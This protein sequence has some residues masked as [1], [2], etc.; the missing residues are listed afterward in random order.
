MEAADAFMHTATSLCPVD[1]GYL[2]SS[3]NA[4]IVGTNAIHVEA[5][6]PYAQYVEYG[7][8]RMSA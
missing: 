7:T 1:T 6:A 3:I 2:L 5:T 4:E 8:S